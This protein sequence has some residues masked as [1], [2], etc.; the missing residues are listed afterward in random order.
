MA[1]PSVLTTTVSGRVCTRSRRISPSSTVLSTS[2]VLSTTATP[3]LS[4]VQVSSTAA[5]LSNDQISSSTALESSRSSE[6]ALLPPTVATTT[7]ESQGTSSTREASAKTSIETSSF[8]FSPSPSSSNAGTL[9]S[10]SLVSSPAA[11]L[12]LPSLSVPPNAF[13]SV[14]ATPSKLSLPSSSSES[15][16]TAKS[17]TI[18]P[19]VVSTSL[20]SASSLSASAAKS[21]IIP[22]PGSAGLISPFRGSGGSNSG[23]VTAGNTPKTD[24]GVLIGG[25]FGG[26][27][28]VALVGALIFMCLRRRQTRETLEAW[29]ERINEKRRPREDQD[30]EL[31]TASTFDRMKAPLAGASLMVTAFVSR[32]T[33]RRLPPPQDEGRRSNI[34]DSVSS[35]YSQSTLARSRSRSEPASRLRQQLQGLSSRMKKSKGTTP[36]LDFTQTPPF[37]DAVNDPLVRG[38]NVNNPFLDPADLREPTLPNLRVM[39]PDASRP[40]TGMLTPRQAIAAGLAGQQRAPITPIVLQRP[41]PTETQNPFL[42]PFDDLAN[43]NQVSTP[44]WLRRPSHSRTQSAQTALQSHPPSSLDGN[45]SFYYPSSINPFAD[46]MQPEIPSLQSQS[47]PSDH[48]LQP[49]SNAYTPGPGP[50]PVSASSRNSQVHPRNY[51]PRI[52]S[53]TTS[54]LFLF[55][56]PGPSRPTTIF[57]NGS[58]SRA[59]RGKSDPFDLDRPEVLGFGAVGSRREVRASVTRQNSRSNRQSS[60]PH[61]VTMDD[62]MGYG[63]SRRSLLPM[64]LR[65]AATTGPGLA[66]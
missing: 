26:V 30:S 14:A 12:P 54:D 1:T 28:G 20:F 59:T 19:V 56:E 66:R 40:S 32:F 13:L 37:L 36:R 3:E 49:P 53:S 6:N 24:V 50:Y 39:N 7:A 45:P 16:T 17:D 57:T 35:V 58:S 55:G 43:R 62:E 41:P 65:K 4:S 60:T 18:N 31:G 48:L 9:S 44:D 34:R 8:V 23:N 52:S 61:W 5:S 2:V 46:P 42:S 63:P 11:S 64:P 22:T 15:P 21:S 47:H 27:I 29:K 10:A 33:S 25:I 38:S 51:N